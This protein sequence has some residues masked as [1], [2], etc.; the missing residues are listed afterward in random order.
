MLLVE[1]SHKYFKCRN[2]NKKNVFIKKYSPVHC[3]CKAF[4]SVCFTGWRL[5]LALVMNEI[6]NFW[7]TYICCCSLSKGRY[8]II[9]R[10]NTKTMKL[11]CKRWRCWKRHLMLRLGCLQ[12]KSWTAQILCKLKSWKYFL[13]LQLRHFIL[14][15]Q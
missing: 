7:V 6:S 12:S 2:T 15:S 1:W 14:S 11:F 10:F 5:K 13:L 4:W 8:C 3:L 9:E